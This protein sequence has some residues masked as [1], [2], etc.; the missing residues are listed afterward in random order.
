MV[1]SIP[2]GLPVAPALLLPKS[3]PEHPNEGTSRG[4]TP[5]PFSAGILP[6]VGKGRGG[7]EED[8]EGEDGEMDVEDGDRFLRPLLDNTPKCWQCDAQFPPDNEF[9][10]I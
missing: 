10:S 4:A 3:F 1:A 7:E 5:D 2:T 8:D 9:G 6:L